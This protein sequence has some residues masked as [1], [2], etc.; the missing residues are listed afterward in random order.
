MRRAL[1]SWGGSDCSVWTVIQQKQ[2][3]HWETL[4]PVEQ[5][6]FLEHSTSLFSGP[7]LHDENQRLNNYK[8]YT[9]SVFVE[10]WQNVEDMSMKMNFSSNPHDKSSPLILNSV[11][12]LL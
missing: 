8:R 4:F 6:R 5:A 11:V 7:R 12:G 2:K 9:Q 10:N 1:C 3:N